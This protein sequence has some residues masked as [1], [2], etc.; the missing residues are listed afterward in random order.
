MDT[1]CKSL[2]APGLLDSALKLQ[3]VLLFYRHPRLFGGAWSLSEWLHESPWALEE[4]LDALS[5]LGF[6]GRF[7]TNGEIRYRLEPSLERWAALERLAR[8][9]DDPLTRD[10]IYQLVHTAD[11][12]RQFRAHVAKELNGVMPV[13]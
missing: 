12:E 7:E 6:I 8:C 3:L 2:L 5:D 11:Q 1:S 4:A 10:T 9:Y 13:W